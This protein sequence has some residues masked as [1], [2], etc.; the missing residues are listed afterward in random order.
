MPQPST[1][2]LNLTSPAT[3]LTGH[4]SRCWMLED[5]GSSPRLKS[6]LIDMFAVSSVAVTAAGSSS[7]PPSLVA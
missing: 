4:H 2:N 5:G 1:L 3:A 7:P 6:V